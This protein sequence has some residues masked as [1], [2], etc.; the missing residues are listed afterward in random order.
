MMQT[1][2]PSR[3]VRTDTSLAEKLKALETASTEE[4]RTYWAELLGGEPPAGTRV[5]LMRSAIAYRIQ[6]QVYGDVR[7]GQAL[8]REGGDNT[9]AAATASDGVR[10]IRSW[11]GEL[12]EVQGVDDRFLYRGQTYRSLSAIARQITGTRWNG[13]TFF[14]VRDRTDLSR[15]VRSV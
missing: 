10:L 2:V 15:G 7:L 5:G 6:A 3:D 11:Q 1:N 8:V 4:L 13:L 14:G 9:G 12:H